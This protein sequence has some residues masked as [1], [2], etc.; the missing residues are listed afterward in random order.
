MAPPR[1]AGPRRLTSSPYD[2]TLGL[3][4]DSAGAD[5]VTG[6]IEVDPSRHTQP[7]GLVHGGL[8][9]S[10]VETLASLG[11]ALS[12]SLE[13]RVP[14]GMENH[15]SFLR[16][17]REGRLDAVARPVA[18]GRSTHLWEVSISDGQGRLVAR[19]SLRLALVEPPDG[20]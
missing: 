8:Y 16:P 12:P 4:I 1:A 18:R 17:V 2:G 3:T 19:G 7:G 6:H 9:C 15:T 13:G 14:V 20:G 11:A 5:A 10:L